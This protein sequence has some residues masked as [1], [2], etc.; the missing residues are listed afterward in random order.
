VDG[1]LKTRRAWLALSVTV[2][3]LGMATK[4]VMVTAPL[5]VFLY[6]R[7][8]VAGSFS[9]AWR[10]RRGYYLALAAT[11]ILLGWLVFRGDG[12]RGV[13][14]GFGLG[15]ST[16]NYL[17]KQCEALVLY[18]R[19]SL[20]P[21]PLVL[22]YGTTV[23]QS[24]AEVWWQGLVVVAALAVTVWALVRRPVAGFAGACFFLILAP[25]SSLVPLVT[26]TM[27]EHRMYLP[28]AA[29]IIPAVV[30]ALR[31]FGRPAV[32]GLGAV[33]VA[34]AV[35]TFVR[36]RDY[37]DAVTIWS[38][39]VTAYPSSARAH[40]NLATALQAARRSDEANTHFTR[41]VALDPAYVSARYNWGV[42]LLEQGRSAEAITQLESAVQLAPDHADARVN[43]GNALMQA[44][45]PAEAVGHYEL[46]LRRQPAADV[47]YNLGVAL[48]DLNR[49]AEAMV[50][51]RVAL[52]GNPA[53]PE[54]HFQMG[55][56]LERASR[57]TEAE[58]EYTATLR[59]SPDHVA[60]HRKLGLMNARRENLA[61]AADHFR[62]VVRREPADAD[63]HA[64][65]G[66]I[67][68]L[69]GQP[70]EAIARYEEALRL[71]P[72]DSRTRENLRLAREALR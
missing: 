70:R 54:A 33:A 1:S 56:L 12:A 39:S 71:R 47:H 23:V 62:A 55:R 40:N 51:L 45:R 36:N 30:L 19:L 3:L 68:L 9:A 29:L 67:L 8:F 59:L 16:W 58:A 7:T 24:P 44:R 53:Q 52:E 60:A 17:L 15:V 41:A 46:A 27:A 20:W 65:L 43:L 57:L 28:L 48:A 64:N 13:A 42:A 49:D 34:C 66:N 72:D 4:E 35:G 14:A 10:A 25:S 18:V 31:G 21:H 38:T 11:W 69:Q 61:S 6:D 37:R 2:C 32:W 26:Q 50:H 63:A 22:D 5:L